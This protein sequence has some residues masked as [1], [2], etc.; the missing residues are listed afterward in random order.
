MQNDYV[1][2]NTNPTVHNEDK[3]EEVEFEN[4]EEVLNEE[5]CRLKLQESLQLIRCHLNISCNF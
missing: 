3:D 5:G 1:S 4:V 2:V